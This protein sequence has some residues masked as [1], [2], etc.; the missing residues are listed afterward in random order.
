MLRSRQIH[1]SAFDHSNNVGKHV[2]H[3][4]PKYAVTSIKGTL[5]FIV[6]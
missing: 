3:V 2:S 6:E 4:A 5:K 1:R